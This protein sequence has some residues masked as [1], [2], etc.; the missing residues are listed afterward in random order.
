MV[1][2]VLQNAVCFMVLACLVPA[3]FTFCME[4]VL[5]LKKLFRRQRVNNR[6]AGSFCFT[7]KTRGLSE[8]WKSAQSMDVVFNF[9]KSARIPVGSCFYL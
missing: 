2:C 4:G 1:C 6:K 9:M 7:G 8:S 3:L 5:E